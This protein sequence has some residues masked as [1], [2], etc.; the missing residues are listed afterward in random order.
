MDEETAREC[1]QLVRVHRRPVGYVTEL[2]NH[3]LSDREV[4]DPLK[5][6]IS[7]IRRNERRAS[8]PGLCSRRR[9]PP[10][11]QVVAASAAAQAA[12]EGTAADAELA[13]LDEAVPP[14]ESPL[15]QAALATLRFVLPAD[16][17]QTV[18]QYVQLREVDRDRGWALLG[19]PNHHVCRAVQTRLREPI[20]AAL[21]LA[22]HMALQVRVVIPSVQG[23]PTLA[24]LLA[25]D[26][27]GPP[28]LLSTASAI[29]PND[30]EAAHDAP[31]DPDEG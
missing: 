8:P 27:A 22:A 21:R 14:D 15:W 6:V 10:T 3:A 9:P 13:P 16:E 7:N 17:Y 11:L 4:R 25:A 31:D 1:A 5:V 20:Q 23:T 2:V 29:V 26:A 28:N 30:P 19:A 12:E 24:E 18:V